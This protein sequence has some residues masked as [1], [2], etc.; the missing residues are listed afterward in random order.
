MKDVDDVM[1]ADLVN[2]FNQLPEEEDLIIYL[3]T[4]GGSA[5]MSM[6]ICDLIEQNQGR[7][8][9]VASGEIYSA[10]F[11]I[12]FKSKCRR[13]IVPGTYGMYHTSRLTV[14]MDVHKRPT[15]EDNRQVLAWGKNYKSKD[16]LEFCKTLPLT[17]Q[18]MSALKKG[19][20]VYFTYERISEFLEYQL[21]LTANEN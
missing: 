16:M 10:G 15:T 12:F 9:L 14:Q 7:V 5:L 2:A 18:E 20:D 13:R 21:R 6:A 11:E 3:S 1:F 8:E 4:D 19:V 17:K